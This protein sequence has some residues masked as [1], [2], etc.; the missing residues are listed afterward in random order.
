MTRPK[1]IVERAWTVAAVD[2]CM[3][4]AIVVVVAASFLRHVDAALLVLR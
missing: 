3:V 2:Y 1:S 4:C